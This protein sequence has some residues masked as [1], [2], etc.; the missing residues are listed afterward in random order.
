MKVSDLC[1]LDATLEDIGRIMQGAVDD[2]EA[3]TD[4][5]RCPGCGASEPVSIPTSKPDDID[6]VWGYGGSHGTL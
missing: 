4:H 5:T 1:G 6:R 3:C 2:C